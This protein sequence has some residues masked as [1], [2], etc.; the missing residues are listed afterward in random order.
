[1]YDETEVPEWSR[2]DEVS[3]ILSVVQTIPDG[4][5]LAVFPSHWEGADCWC[6]PHVDF[7]LGEFVVHHKNLAI[8]EFDT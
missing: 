3:S 7:V 8:G 1:M 6:R 4:V 5:R 2:C